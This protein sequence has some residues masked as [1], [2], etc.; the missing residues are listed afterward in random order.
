MR[1]LADRLEIVSPERKR[2]ELTK[3]LLAPDPVAGLRVFVDSGAADHVLPELPRLKATVDE[4]GRHK[5]VYEHTLTVLSRAAALERTRG[6]QPDLVLRMAA[7]LHDIGKPDTRMFDKQGVVTFHHHES[8]GA[9]M[10]QARLTALRYPKADVEDVVHLV[11]MH[12]RFHGYAG[13]EWTDAAVRRYVRDA[14]DQ[15]ERLHL[16]TRSD[17]TTRNK[18]K[19]GRLAAAYDALEQ[20]IAELAAREELAAIRPDLDGRQVMA[21]LGV[22][23]GPVVG[24]ALSFLLDLRLEHGPLGADKAR[25]ELLRWAAERGV[26]PPASGRGGSSRKK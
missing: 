1:A 26:V 12:L 8:V 20:R 19:A 9:R 21:E 2:D 16:L 5:D 17:C 14:G 23:A 22:P 10:A 24:E 25:A 4:H 6:L 3:L 18:A 15:L 13:G 11:E 7:L